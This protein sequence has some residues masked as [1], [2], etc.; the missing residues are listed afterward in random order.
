MQKACVHGGNMK[1]TISIVIAG[2]GGRG[3]LAYAPYTKKY[4]EKMKL[5]GVAEPDDFRRARIREEYGLAEEQC[6]SDAKQLFAVPR[7][8]D[9]A[10]ICTQDRQHVEHALLAMRQGY[11]ILLEKP[12]S[13]YADECRRLY[14]AAC[15]CGALV[16]VCHVLRYAPFYRKIKELLER[17]AIG[18]IISIQAAENVGYWHYTHS[19][20]RG[21]WRNSKETSPMILAKCC[22]DMDLFVWL[23]ESRC[24][25]ISSMGALTYFREKNA[26]C[27]APGYCMQGCPKKSDCPFDAEKIYLT[28][29]VN[30]SGQN[31]TDWMQREVS[32]AR[33]EACL[34]EA[35]YDGPYGRCVFRCDNDVVDHQVVCARMENGVTIS[36]SMCGFHEENYRT[37]HIMGTAGELYGTIEEDRLVLQPFGQEAVEIVT[38]AEGD[39]KSHG[40]GDEQMMEDLYEAVTEGG[41]TLTGLG[42]SLESHYMALAAEESRMEGGKKIELQKF[43]MQE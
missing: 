38:A 32:G 26:P 37:I 21:K 40:G 43:R 36:F 2:A 39:E 11:D 23:T 41:A 29:A 18:E 7:M 20:V 8:A 12:V 1:K 16:T 28:N 15:G 19:Y 35:L 25:T 17:R 4:P 14:R 27:G 22:H 34:R 31:G 24:H 5:V 9:I 42:D 13:P 33:G 30:A 10:F 6:F 3:F